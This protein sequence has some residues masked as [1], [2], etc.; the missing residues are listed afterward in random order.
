MSV[1]YNV[2]NDTECLTHHETRHGVRFTVRCNLHW[3]KNGH[4]V[5]IIHPDGT[6]QAR[7]SRALYDTLVQRGWIEPVRIP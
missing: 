3:G 4:R 7:L 5:S 6:A 2:T 1:A